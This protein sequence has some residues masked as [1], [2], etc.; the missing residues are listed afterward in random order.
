MGGDG[1]TYDGQGRAG[2]AAIGGWGLANERGGCDDGGAMYTR[3]CTA[4]CQRDA[5]DGGMRRIMKSDDEFDRWATIDDRWA[6]MLKNGPEVENMIIIAFQRLHRLSPSRS[7]SS[8]TFSLLIL[9]FRSY[10][11]HS[12]KFVRS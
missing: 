9:F 2:D 5:L 3:L 12:F 10:H 1:G 8:L 4:L 6:M 7:C 11:T